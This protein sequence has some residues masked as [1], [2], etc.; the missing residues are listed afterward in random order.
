MKSSGNSWRLSSSRVQ[1]LRTF[2]LLSASGLQ[3]R[4]PMRYARSDLNSIAQNKSPMAQTSEMAQVTA[5]LPAGGGPSRPLAERGCVEVHASLAACNLTCAHLRLSGYP[6]SAFACSLRLYALTP[7][8]HFL[9]VAQRQPVGQL[10]ARLLRYAERQQFVRAGGGAPAATHLSCSGGK[11]IMYL[12]ISRCTC[13]GLAAAQQALLQRRHFSSIRRALPTCSGAPTSRAAS[14][15]TSPGSADGC[16]RLKVSRIRHNL[17]SGL[18]RSA[19]HCA[20]AAAA[21]S[22]GS[23]SSSSSPSRTPDPAPPRR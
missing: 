17:D 15:G 10:G 5:Q 19:R 7:S 13:G 20:T 21:D 1:D 3:V 12:N 22:D 18:A 23:T 2:G 8:V 6:E 4:C 14:G 11:L 9:R 16:E